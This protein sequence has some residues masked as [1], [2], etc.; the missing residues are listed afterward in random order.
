[1]EILNA[2]LLLVGG[3][4]ALS[5][6]IVAKRPDAKRLIDQLV[7]FQ[8]LIGVGLLA[9]GVINLLRLLGSHIFSVI[10]HMA[11]FGVTMLSLAVT[12]ILLGF[13]FGMPQIAKWAPGN[14]AA[15]QKGLELMAK[16]APY[17]VVLGGVAVATS[18][19]VLLYSSGI[20]SP[21]SL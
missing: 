2:L 14:A 19:L 13:L 6:L 12:S 20:I 8:A 9:L 21:L 11:V 17:Q 3:I 5:G 18:L 16:L 1:M 10:S 7:P 4:L 15:E